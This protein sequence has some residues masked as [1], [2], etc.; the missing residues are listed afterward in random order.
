MDTEHLID[1]LFTTLDK[2]RNLPDYQL[3]RR[4]DI[5][6]G[7]YLYEIIKGKFNEKIEFLI[8]EFPL[9]IGTLD[10]TEKFTHPNMSK[11]IDYVAITTSNKV[12][13]IE[14][15]TDDNSRNKKQDKYLDKAKEVNI[16]ELVDG[17]LKINKASKAKIK[18][19]QL[20][21]LL[22]EI[23]WINKT[24]NNWTN[25]STDCTDISIVYIQ[26]NSAKTDKTDKTIISFEDIIGYLNNKND[27][28]TKRFVESLKKWIINPGIL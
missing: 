9:R 14:L 28:L 4:A 13:F 7:I 10:P 26:P 21:N 8:P 11:K 24:E 12:F 6:F 2:W 18:Y 5:F 23:G 27:A 25:A 3:E 1:K 22:K 20:L 19:G 16:K 15:K 17:I